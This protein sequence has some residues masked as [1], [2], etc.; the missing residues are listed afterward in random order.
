[1][2]KPITRKKRVPEGVRAVFFD[3]GNVLIDYDVPRALKRFAW[4]IRSHPVRVARLLLS[5]RMVEDV[6]RGKISGR[7]MFETFKSELEFK[8]SFK[9]FKTLW[10]GPFKLNTGTE[11]LLRRVADRCPT[12][13]LSN[14]NQLHYDYIRKTFDFTRVVRSAVLS[15]RLGLRKPE[16][17]IYAAALRRARVS[18]REALF[19]DDLKDN[20]RAA[21]KAGWRA[22]HYRGSRSLE[23]ELKKLG[24][25]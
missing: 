24:V 13:L 14:T 2:N 16:S 22:I 7:V 12:Y 6:E 17:A 15:Y 1:M 20:V 11:G 9:E 19:I 5:R 25:L 21:R 23:R 18:A 4:A 8:G 10:N 3:I